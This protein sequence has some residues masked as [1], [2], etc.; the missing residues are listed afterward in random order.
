[1]WPTDMGVHLLNISKKKLCTQQNKAVRIINKGCYQDHV[2]SFY[3]S[4]KILKMTDLFK[5]EIAKIVYSHFQKKLPPLLS[6]LFFKIN[7]ISTKTTRSSYPTK[8]FLLYIPK[9]RFSRLQRNIMYQGVKIWNE[10][11]FEVRS[12]N[13]NQFKLQY[14][15]YLLKQY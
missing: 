4:L 9:F 14:K 1:M 15:N 11:P 3:S 8:S 7:D 2:S 10:I 5:L 13:F 12:K 6:D